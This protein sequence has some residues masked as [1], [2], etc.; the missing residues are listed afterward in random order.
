MDSQVL[1]KLKEGCQE[2]IERIDYKEV[3]KEEFRERFE[4]LNVPCLITGVVD[5]SWGWEKNW[6]WKVEKGQ[7]RRYTQSTKTQR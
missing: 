1:E 7:T 3:E 6:S 5:E 4:L 2:N